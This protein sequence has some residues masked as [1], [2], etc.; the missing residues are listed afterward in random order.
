M[1][2]KVSKAMI[3]MEI[4]MRMTPMRVDGVLIGAKLIIAHLVMAV[5]IPI[6]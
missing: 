2:L 6:V 3:Q 5:H 4:I 1:I